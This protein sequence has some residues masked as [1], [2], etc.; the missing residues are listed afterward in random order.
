[1]SRVRRFTEF[2]RDAAEI[3]AGAPIALTTGGGIVRVIGS[4]VSNPKVSAGIIKAGN[5]LVKGGVSLAKAYA[6]GATIGAKALGKGIKASTPAIKAVAKTLPGSKYVPGLVKFA[7]V[8]VPLYLT[9]AG[10]VKLAKEAQKVK[11][12]TGGAISRLG[13]DRPQFNFKSVLDTFKNALLFK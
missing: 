13:S 10:G 5:A 11:Q 9:V 3:V 6:K 1:M 12:L 2:I 8:G 7:K 4:S